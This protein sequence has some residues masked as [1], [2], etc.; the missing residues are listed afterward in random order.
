[1][2]PD[3]RLRS[4]RRTPAYRQIIEKVVALVKSGRIQAGDK[5]PPERE[6]AEKLGV[7]RGTVK[8]AYEELARSHVIEVSQGRG[9]FVSSRQNV[10]ATRRKDKAVRVVD[11]MIAELT[12]LKFS[13]REIRALVDLKVI[14]QEER[15]Q[16]FHLAVVD[17]NPEAL[18][19][20]ER[21]I[22]SL[23]RSNIARFLLDDL[24]AAPHP[25]AMLEHFGLI[26]TT[27]T[28]Y[29]ELIGLVPSLRERI[30][31]AVVSPRQESVIELARI[32]SSQKVGVICQSAQFQRIITDKLHDLH[33]HAARVTTLLTG[34]VHDLA[35]FLADRTVVIVPPGYSLVRRRDSVAA[36]QAFRARGGRIIEFDYQIERGSLLQIEERIRALLNR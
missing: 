8:K 27:A 3:I 23:S 11:N 15:L 22:V 14:E 30:V 1:M 24:Q 31:Q 12:D 6:L 4:D 16:N 35:G 25:E 28:H 36:A 2:F 33:I 17:C 26:V 32:T 13:Y 19:I 18:A 34:E 29:S 20:Y 5:L 10:V 21:Q 7:A 9:S